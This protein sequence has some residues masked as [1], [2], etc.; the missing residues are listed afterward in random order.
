M[1]LTNLNAASQ[2]ALAVHKHLPRLAVLLPR[3]S[4]T[5]RIRSYQLHN[6]R[7]LIV[8][9]RRVIGVGLRQRHAFHELS[10]GAETLRNDVIRWCEVSCR[11]D[12][13][14]GG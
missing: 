8:Q 12:M 9:L 13:G 1:F 11:A 7:F 5:R 6:L 10:A 4:V 3:A 2:A 14:W